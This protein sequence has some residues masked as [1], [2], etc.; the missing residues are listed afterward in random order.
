[1]SSSLGELTLSF[2][3]WCFGFGL[4]MK[5]L[6]R[7]PSGMA[8]ERWLERSHNGLVNDNKLHSI[9]NFRFKTLA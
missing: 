2:I 9:S 4:N 3:F 6:G 1:V 5:G 8:A 7:N